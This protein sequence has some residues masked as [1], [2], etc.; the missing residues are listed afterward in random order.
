MEQI[1]KRGNP[2]WTPGVS[3]NTN[4]RPPGIVDAR[5]RFTAA[6]LDDLQVTWS[7]HGADVMAR[8]A[9]TS[10]EAFFSVCA[11]LCSA[12]VQ[13]SIEQQFPGGL[14]AT[15]IASLKGI[16]ESVP[17]ADSRSPADV[18]DYVRDTLRAAEATVIEPSE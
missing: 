8:V 17:D 7:E 9:K 11:R 5:H 13:L 14:D 4:G 3:G 6:F 2:N 15:D 18:L 16:R 1:A 12:N 10:P